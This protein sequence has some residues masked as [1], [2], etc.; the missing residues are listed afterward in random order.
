MDKAILKKMSKDAL[1]KLLREEYGD[2]DVSKEM[3]KAE[4]IN[5]I[6]NYADVLKEL[7]PHEENDY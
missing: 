4:L 5:T 2:N 6:L 7:F 1:I 3:S